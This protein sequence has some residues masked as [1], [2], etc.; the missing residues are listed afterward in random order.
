M[1]PESVHGT[2]PAPTVSAMLPAHLQFERRCYCPQVQPSGW[3]TVWLVLAD[4]LVS[5]LN[6]DS[7]TL[8]ACSLVE[9]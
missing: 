6:L 9:S 4:L 5:K 1:T 2:L 7:S 8:T 3:V